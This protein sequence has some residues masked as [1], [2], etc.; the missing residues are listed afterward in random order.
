MVF[1][2]LETWW[3]LGWVSCPELKKK[4]KIAAFE[5]YIFLVELWVATG[6]I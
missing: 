1:D 4:K 2:F 6:E 5:L 3:S